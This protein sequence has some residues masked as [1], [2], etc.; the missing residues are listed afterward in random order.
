MKTERIAVG[1]FPAT[2]EGFNAGVIK[3]IEMQAV[4]CADGLFS[5]VNFLKKRKRKISREN[6]L[7]IFLTRGNHFFSFVCVTYSETAGGN[8][9]T[10]VQ[11]EDETLDERGRM[12]LPSYCD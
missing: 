10:V 12:R 4:H 3:R 5:A 1:P 6:L 7:I 11:F 9:Y 2:V 8:A